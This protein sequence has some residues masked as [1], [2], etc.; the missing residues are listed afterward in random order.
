M[1]SIVRPAPPAAAPLAARRA[2]RPHPAPRSAP[3]V[4]AVD[5]D[6]PPAPPATGGGSEVGALEAWW[7]ERPSL[8]AVADRPSPPHRRPLP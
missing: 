6:A 8:G 5:M 4:C 3:R 1:A 2:R 7:R